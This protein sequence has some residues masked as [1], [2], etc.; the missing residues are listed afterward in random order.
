MAFDNQQLE[1]WEREQATSNRE[2]AI[3][4]AA[5]ERAL[6]R[7]KRFIAG[8]PNAVS[9]DEFRGVM[10]YDRQTGAATDPYKMRGILNAQE[11]AM[12]QQQGQNAVNVEKEHALGLTNQ[13]SV[14]AGYNRDA[15]IKAAELG[16]EGSK[17]GADKNLDAAKL[18]ADLKQKVAGLQFGTVGEDGKITPGSNERVAQLQME[19]EAIAAAAARET[20]IR[21]QEIRAGALTDAATIKS[22][23]DVAAAQV[24]AQHAE[25]VKMQ[26]FYQDV[27]QGKFN[28]PGG[29]KIDPEKFAAMTDEEKRKLYLST[30]GASATSDKSGEPANKTWKTALGW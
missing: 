8:N 26:R 16:L 4:A 30:I 21:Q 27:S 14:A 20:A 6:N 29:I 15:A 22:G 19:A 11:M 2:D 13:G 25:E 18:D 28:Q 5:S 3:F 1:K 10:G 24:K 23:A 7:R 9:P 17:Y 12:L